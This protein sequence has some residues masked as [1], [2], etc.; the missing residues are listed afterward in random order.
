MTIW[1]SLLPFGI[2]NGHSVIVFTFPPFWYIKPR[3]IWQ[4]CRGCLIQLSTQINTIRVLHW[5]SLT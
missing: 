1:N 2:F 5:N 3:K 4:P